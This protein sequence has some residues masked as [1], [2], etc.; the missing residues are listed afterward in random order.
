MLINGGAFGSDYAIDSHF[1]EAIYVLAEI[2][3]EMNLQ[4]LG[5]TQ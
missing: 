1:T 3:S 2:L 5:K 4:F